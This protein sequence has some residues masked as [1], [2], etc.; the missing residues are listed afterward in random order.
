M[1]YL[2]SILRIRIYHFLAKYLYEANKTKKE[3]IVY[4][5]IN[6]LT[7]SI[8]AVN[9]KIITENENPDK[10]IDIVA[11]LLDFH[12]HQK[13]K[14]VKILTTKQM[15]QRLPIVLAQVKT[16]NTSEN[17]LTEI[18]RLIY[19]SNEADEVTKKKYITL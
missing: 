7:G 4:Q 6:A 11:K 13:G 9:K 8:N 18:R 19:S 16:V 3:Q 17:V 2:R 14:G 1:K 12:K 15:L 5:M 10:V